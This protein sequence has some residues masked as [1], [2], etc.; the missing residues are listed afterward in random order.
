MQFRRASEQDREVE[1]DAGSIASG[2]SSTRFGNQSLSV[3]ERKNGRLSP[4]ERAR[5]RGPKRK[6]KNDAIALAKRQRGL[7]LYFANDKP[8]PWTGMDTSCNGWW[9]KISSGIKQ[10]YFAGILQFP[11]SLPME[12]TDLMESSLRRWRGSYRQSALRT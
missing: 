4:Y 10:P 12:M 7:Q 11:S 8:K 3:E 5:R 6:W 9:P 1:P 2:A